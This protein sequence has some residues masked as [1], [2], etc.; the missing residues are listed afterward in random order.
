[1]ENV[2]NIKDT[3]PTVLFFGL[4]EFGLNAALGTWRMEVASTK[5]KLM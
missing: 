5:F 1:M 2:E 4:E 3:P